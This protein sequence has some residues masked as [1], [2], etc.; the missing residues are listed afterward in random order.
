MN[1]L[2]SM[3]HNYRHHRGHTLLAVEGQRV[4][5]CA[6]MFDRTKVL[7]DLLADRQAADVIR[8]LIQHCVIMKEDR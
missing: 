1:G 8:E 3:L 7:F 5:T 4:G 6:A 2:S